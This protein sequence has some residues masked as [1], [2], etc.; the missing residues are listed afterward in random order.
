MRSFETLVVVF[1]GCSGSGGALS[2][3]DKSL[4]DAAGEGNGVAVAAALKAGAN[5]NC[6]S[7]EAGETPLVCP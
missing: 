3:L 5:I 7:E 2:P 1:I 6:R 4:M